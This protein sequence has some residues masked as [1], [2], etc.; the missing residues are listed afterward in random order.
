ME[1]FGVVTQYNKTAQTKQSFAWECP[2]CG[3]PL[4]TAGHCPI[5]GS[6]PFEP[7]YEEEE[8]KSTE[9]GDSDVGRVHVK[10]SEV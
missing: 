8:R 1:K 6:E 3:Q 7:N 9:N 2:I 10:R 5:H 4:T